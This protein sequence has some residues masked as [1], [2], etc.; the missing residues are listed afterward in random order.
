MPK[1]TFEEIKEFLLQSIQ[2]HKCE[3]ELSLFF[4]DNPNEYMIIIYEDHC[5][6]QRC[7]NIE[8][9][10]GEYNYATLDELYQATQIDNIILEKDW[11]KVTDIDCFA[12]DALGIW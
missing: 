12:F 1:F 7:G 2:E 9:T 10:S 4:S 8:N 3:A 11:T 6:F 5:S